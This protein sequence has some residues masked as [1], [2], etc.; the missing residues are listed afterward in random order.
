MGFIVNIFFKI[1]RLLSFMDSLK[2]NFRV[3]F[4]TKVFIHRRS[5]RSFTILVL[6][7]LMDFRCYSFLA[8]SQA[9]LL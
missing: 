1:Y 3:G 8:Q 6:R 9:G 2:L 4:K 5:D 7:A